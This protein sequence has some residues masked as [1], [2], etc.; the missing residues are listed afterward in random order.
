MV[1][2]R[3][4]FAETSDDGYAEREQQNAW[5]QTVPGEEATEGCFQAI[6]ASSESIVFQLPFPW[7]LQLDMHN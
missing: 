2:K 5:D 6:T 7:S 3:E 4:S 1:L